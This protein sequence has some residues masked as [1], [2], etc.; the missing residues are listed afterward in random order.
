MLA[1]L[2]HATL[3]FG[4]RLILED[5]TVSVEQGDRIGL[6][7]ANGAGKT[8]LLRLL[9][10]ELSCDEG[11]VAIPGSVR[12]GFLRQNSGLTEGSTVYREMESVFAELLALQAEMTDLQNRLSTLS[13]DSADYLELSARYS[14]LN[15]R[16]EAGEGYQI[17]VK[18]KTVLTGM[19]FA[20]ATY[21]QRI[22]SLSG[23]EK[24]RL[25]LCRLLLTAP[26]LLILDEPTNH[27]D[28]TTLN[29]LEEYLSGYKGG[30]LVVSHDRYFL[31]R[32]VNRIWELENCRL[33]SYPGNYT[34]YKKLR[35]E[36][37]ER[38]EKEYE[39]DQQKIAEL[40]DYIN[41]NLTRAST[42]GMAKSRR[43]QLERMTPAEKPR[44]Y[45]PTP[46]FRF[47]FDRDPV[48]DVL[49]V[50]NLSLTVG[51]DESRRTLLPP[52]S[53]SLLRGE[54]TAIIGPN[55]VG[56]STLLRSLQGI[57]RQTGEI[58]WGQHVRIGYYD[59]ELRRLDPALTAL[60]ALWSRFPTMQEAE[61]RRLLGQVNLVG[62]NSLKPVGVL[63]GGEKARVAM[64]LL[65]LERPNVLLLDE[66]TNHLD[67]YSREALEQ[68]LLDFE[69]TLLFVSHD[70]Y[71]LNTIPT[72][73]LV[74]SPEGM[75][76]C[77]GNYDSYQATLKPVTPPPP[78]PPQ[79][80]TG[81][82]SKQQR[83]AQA[84]L[85]ERRRQLEQTVEAAE[86]RIA[87]IEA[88]LADPDTSSDY[89][90]LT[91]LCAELEET[92]ARHEE[93]LEKWLLLNDE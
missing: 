55:G 37:L 24:T 79:E 71:L 32:M 26:D 64:A 9:C 84:K 33:I 54:R 2:D 14:T 75:T 10:G 49:S 13:P 66:P 31:D 5:L 91:G 60:E 19:G 34:K 83:A 43:K 29:W 15:T 53:F 7:G 23:G 61:L 67:L 57:L 68:S 81:F 20:P 6:V 16:F 59:Q 25:A 56:K 35:A 36:R 30:I 17:P 87:E 18:I 8:T 92:R 22:D 86:T 42:S 93:A 28:F 41:R 38:M 82:R 48:K 76:V 72:R 58:R 80:T 45:E 51:E 40:T 52:L 70:R 73:L 62:E 69:G 88:L 78:P 1:S 12:L 74:L 85:R 3:Y 89:E 77:Q 46:R 90:A 44:P 63:S 39:A 50:E 4:D 47:V 65:M 21:D 27:L 11:R